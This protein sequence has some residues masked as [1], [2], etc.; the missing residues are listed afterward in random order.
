MGPPRATRGVGKPES[1][2]SRLSQ[3]YSGVKPFRAELQECE[4]HHGY[5][6]LSVYSNGTSP[7]DADAFVASSALN[8]GFRVSGCDTVVRLDHL[9]WQITGHV[10]R[11]SEPSEGVSM[12]VGG[13]AVGGGA[14]AAGLSRLRTRAAHHQPKAEFTAMLHVE[15]VGQCHA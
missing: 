12:F 10:V 5:G 9:I 2:G 11:L 8:E 6:S 3:T 7:S 1:P 14:V 4:Y 15:A 13:I